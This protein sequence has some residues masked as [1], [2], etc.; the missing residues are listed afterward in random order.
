[1]NV[2]EELKLNIRIPM[3]FMP[4]ASA[5]AEK[6]WSNSLDTSNTDNAQFRLDEH[7][8]R[9]LRRGIPAQ[10][11]LNGFCGDYEW[12]TYRSKT[13]DNYFTNTSSIEVMR[14]KT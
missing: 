10:P 14:R 4:R 6:L 11:I 5:V 8:C 7:R 12:N 13:Y 2:N 3:A 1:M 9:L